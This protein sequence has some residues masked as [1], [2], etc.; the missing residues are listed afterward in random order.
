MTGKVKKRLG[1]ILTKVG[2]AV[3]IFGVF[4]MAINLK[5]T[6]T[7]GMQEV[8]FYKGLLAAAP[9]ML[10]AGAW[11]GREGRID[12]AESKKR[13]ELE[14]SSQIPLSDE[15]IRSSDRRSIS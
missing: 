1:N 11:F 5:I 4:A 2:A 7:P 8:L 6:I 15:P 14:S 9:M 12:E 3:G 10:I 13:A